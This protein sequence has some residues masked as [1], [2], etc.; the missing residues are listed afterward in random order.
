MRNSLLII[1]LILVVL[2]QF[3]NQLFF[4]LPMIVMAILI[5]LSF[6]VIEKMKV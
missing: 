4:E 1:I 2:L 3:L 6:L 5:V